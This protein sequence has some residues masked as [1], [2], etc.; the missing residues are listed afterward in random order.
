MWRHQ[1]LIFWLL[2]CF[3]SGESFHVYPLRSL[4]RSLFRNSPYEL[5]KPHNQVGCK[6][7]YKLSASEEDDESSE[8]SED[9][10]EPPPAESVP[11]YGTTLVKNVEVC[12][13]N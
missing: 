8:W 13:M 9:D 2:T 11:L 4:R 10:L 6:Y 1:V 12:Q 3:L 7:K 5:R